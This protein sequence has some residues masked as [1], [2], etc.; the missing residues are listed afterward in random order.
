MHQL[1]RIIDNYGGEICFVDRDFI[2]EDGKTKTEKVASIYFGALTPFIEELNEN[3]KKLTPEEFE[4]YKTRFPASSD[5]WDEHMI[6]R[7]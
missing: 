3:K 5:E 1:Y 2:D 7:Q 6:P 4:E